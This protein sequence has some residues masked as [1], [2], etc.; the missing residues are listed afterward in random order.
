MDL[1]TKAEQRYKINAFELTRKRENLYLSVEQFA[2][3]IGWSTSYQYQLEEGKYK[4]V[5]IKIAK[6]IRSAFARYGIGIKIES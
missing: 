1:F 2:E 3:I 6:E 5:S 4:T